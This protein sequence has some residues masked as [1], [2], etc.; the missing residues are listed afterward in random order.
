[1]VINAGLIPPLVRV[2]VTGD[3][4]T[5][6]EAAWAVSN[7]TVGGSPA[8]VGTFPPPPSTLKCPPLHFHSFP[9]H[10]PS[11][12]HCGPEWSYWTHVSAP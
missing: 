6:K 9:L 2:L 7:L 4:K 5:K 8:Q 3:F 11:G 1:M 12:Q 10:L